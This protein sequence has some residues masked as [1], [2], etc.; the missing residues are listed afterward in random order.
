MMDQPLRVEIGAGELIDKIT[1]LRIKAERLKDATQL[2]NVQRELELLCAVRD[3]ALA[4]VP[5]LRELTSQLRGINARLW[6]LE[7]DIRA[8]EAAGDFG[9][10]FIAAA[11]AIYRS[12]DCRSAIKREINR[13]SGSPIVEEKLYTGYE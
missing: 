5:T 4:N 10:A 11:R 12:N 13:L 8:C 1:I 2:A 6:Q 7:D 9:A 3:E